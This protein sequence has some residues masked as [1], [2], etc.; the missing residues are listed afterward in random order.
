[1]KKEIPQ[2][3]SKPVMEIP[4]KKGGADCAF[5]SIFINFYWCAS[6][7]MRLLRKSKIDFVLGGQ[8]VKS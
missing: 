5:H 3:H 2:T 7:P 8:I 1:M 4:D 6:F